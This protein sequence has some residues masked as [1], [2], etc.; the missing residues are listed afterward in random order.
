V[1]TFFTIAP[2]KMGAIK[3]GTVAIVLEIPNNIPEKEPDISFMFTL[4]KRI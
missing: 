4:N 2:T 1:L 3:P